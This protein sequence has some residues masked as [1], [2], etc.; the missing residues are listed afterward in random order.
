MPKPIALALSVSAVVGWRAERD[1]E[2]LW[3]VIDAGPVPALFCVRN[4]GATAAS[5]MGNAAEAAPF[6]V[7]VTL[8]APAAASYG[9]WTIRVASD[10]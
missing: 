2:A 10:A 1:G 6:S 9:I 3:L 5:V 4:A 8:E 7:T